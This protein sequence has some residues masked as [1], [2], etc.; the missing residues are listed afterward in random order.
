MHPA[1]KQKQRAVR[2]RGHNTL[3]NFIG[4][5]FPRRDDPDNEEFYH[6]CMLTLLKP[7]RDLE[8]DLKP[9]SQSW[10]EAFDLF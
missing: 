9:G 4:N 5:Y 2:S 1:Y 7:W 6:A 10:K 8:T 3:P